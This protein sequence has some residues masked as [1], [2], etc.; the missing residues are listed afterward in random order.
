MFEIFFSNN[1]KRNY[2]TIFYVLGG[3]INAYACYHPLTG[4]STNY[5]IA[6]Y[7]FCVAF[8]WFVIRL[9]RKERR[10]GRDKD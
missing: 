4:N 6:G 9:I 8:V 2:S 3:L 1:R 7:L 5:M 10:K